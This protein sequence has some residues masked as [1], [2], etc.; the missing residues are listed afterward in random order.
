M[1]RQKSAKS[2]VGKLALALSKAVFVAAIRDARVAMLCACDDCK[3][4]VGK[5]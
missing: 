1:Q 2:E 4:K 3:R 5:W